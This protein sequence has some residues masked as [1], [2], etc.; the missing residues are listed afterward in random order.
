MPDGAASP[1]ATQPIPGASP[2]GASARYEPDFEAMQAEISKLENPAGGEVRW[3][4]VQ[5]LAEKLLKDKSKDMLIGSY[6][7]VARLSREGMTGLTHGLGVLLGMSKTF[8]DTMFPEIKRLKARESALEWMVDRVN[9]HLER[10]GLSDP[11]G[12]K[13]AAQVMNELANFVNGKLEAPNPMLDGMVRALNAKAT[14]AGPA[15]AAGGQAAAAGGGQAAPVVAGPIGN[16]KQAFDRLKEVAD[17]LRKTEPHSPVSYL[18]NRAVK[19]GNMT[20]E[21]VLIELVK[22]TD[23]RK[24]LFETLGVKENEKRDSQGGQSN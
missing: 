15:A 21:D 23:A 7:A 17:F 1:L 9:R 3:P 5:E 18:V 24:Q 11:A 13:A 16:R 14:G 2:A 4:L 12:C 10:D 20:L 22:N 8:W 19:W 6:Y